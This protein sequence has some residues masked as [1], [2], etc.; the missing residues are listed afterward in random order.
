MVSST[1]RGQRMRKKITIEMYI[2]V[3]DGNNG[4]LHREV[5]QFVSHDFV[6]LMQDGHDVYV[7]QLFDPVIQIEN[8][9]D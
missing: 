5:N 9:S 3:E 4:R 2:E 1:E 6:E 7:T 8:V